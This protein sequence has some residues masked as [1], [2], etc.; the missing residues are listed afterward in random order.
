MKVEARNAPNWNQA[1]IELNDPKTPPPPQP[2]TQSVTQQAGQS[3]AQSAMRTAAQPAAQSAAPAAE[4]SAGQQAER[5][6]AQPA[7]QT[8]AQTGGRGAYQSAARSAA[9]PDAQSAVQPAGPTARTPMAFGQTRD[10]GFKAQTEGPTDLKQQ[11]LAHPTGS[12]SASTRPTP[13]APGSE[14]EELVR[15]TNGNARIAPEVDASIKA[16]QPA[17]PQAAAAPSTAAAQQPESFWDI[18][19]DTFKDPGGR[20]GQ[21]FKNIDTLVKEGRYATPQENADARRIG[22]MFNAPLQLAVPGLGIAGGIASTVDVAQ[23]SAK[24]E[25]VDPGVLSDALPS[26][27]GGSSGSRASGRPETAGTTSGSTGIGSTANGATLS[28]LPNFR[29]PTRLEDGRIGYPLSPTR[30]PK[31]PEEG[32]QRGAGSSTM[33]QQPPAPEAGPSGGRVGPRAEAKPRGVVNFAEETTV[34]PGTRASYRIDD[35]YTNNYRGKGYE[36]IVLH[37]KATPSGQASYLQYQRG[38]QVVEETGDPNQPPQILQPFAE[39]SNVSA[40]QLVQKLNKNHG[41]DLVGASRGGKGPDT[42]LYLLACHGTRGGC[43]SSAAQGMANY[44]GREV[45]A[46]SD[47]VIEASNP[48]LLHGNRNYR[49]EAGQPEPG[50]AAPPGTFMPA[51]QRAL[52]RARNTLAGHGPT[53][54]LPHKRFYPQPG[55]TTEQDIV[56]PTVAPPPSLASTS[57]GSRAQGSE[58]PTTSFGSVPAQ[59]SSYNSV[60]YYPPTTHPLVTLP[61]SRPQSSMLG[62]SGASEGGRDTPSSEYRLPGEASSSPSSST[63]SFT[64]SP[65]DSPHLAYRRPGVKRATS[66]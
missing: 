33:G 61:G 59:S 66:S 26:L 6:A 22:S 48:S 7:G 36:A 5:S 42:P 63:G 21:S 8:A 17:R 4:Q 54:A 34:I 24:G 45:R 23:R 9:G 40:R 62:Y 58:S 56:R 11:R 49:V 30:A 41:I 35:G 32:A 14:T 10:M 39:V 57:M 55:S 43:A 29:P 53:L 50:L 46:Y 12:T 1:N 16:S 44:T 52:L 60:Q 31:L 15:G 18:V 28:A 25:K 37:G 64:P 13:N 27:R 19:R 3:Q 20:L 2:Q 51:A 38:K 65:P 47:Y